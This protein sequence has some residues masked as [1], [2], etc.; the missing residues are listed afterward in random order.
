MTPDIEKDLAMVLDALLRGV[1]IAG[2]WRD[3][4]EAAVARIREQLEALEQLAEAAQYALPVLQ[5]YS[6]WS[7]DEGQQTAASQMHEAHEVLAAALAQI[8]KEK[9]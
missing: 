4:A 9:P 5:E 2:P 7:D 8:R 1:P 3:E 6:I